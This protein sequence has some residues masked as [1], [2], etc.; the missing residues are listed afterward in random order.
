[1]VVLPVF[2]MILEL[3]MSAVHQLPVML[4]VLKTPNVQEAKMVVLLAY[5]ITP[6]LEMFAGLQLPVV[7][8]VL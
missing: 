4:V 1:M 6:A 7:S 5:P 2:L 8:L 3:V